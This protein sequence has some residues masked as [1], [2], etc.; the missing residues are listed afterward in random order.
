MDIIIEAW[1]LLGE[2]APYLLL[3]FLVAG[4]LSVMI[5]AG[6]VERHL[7]RRGWRQIVKASLLGV[8]LPLCSC[9]V[10]PVSASLRRHGASKGATVSFLASTPQ[11]GVDS[12][13]ATYALLGP[14]FTLFRVIT[15]FVS[16]V[17]SGLFSE[18]FDHSE[19]QN[20]NAESCDN[21]DACHP[22]A[23]GRIYRILHYG[24]VALPRDIGKA[25]L[26]GVLISGLLG[27]LLP[28]DFFAAHVGPGLP[29]M[30]LMLVIGIPLYVCSTGSIPLAFAMMRLGIS[31]GAALVFLVSGPATNAAALATMWR[32]LGKRTVLI[33]LVVIAV[34]SLAAGLLLNN[35]LPSHYDIGTHH[36]HVSPAVSWINHIS[37][38]ILLAVLLNAVF[39]RYTTGQQEQKSTQ[40]R[41]QLVIRG[42]RCSH[43]AETVRRALGSLPGIQ[44]VQ[45]DLRSGEA[46]WTGPADTTEAAAREIKA[47]GY[48]ISTGKS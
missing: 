14:I 24:F 7:G 10:I 38:G 40:S 46:Q 15:A 4:V 22:A 23:R 29:S 3:G 5:P 35:I 34:T 21:C 47:L 2:M 9:G 26:L 48:E 19:D 37:A 17:V 36:M 31:P 6:F 12:I 45:I 41:Q 33:Y 43:C 11:T 18:A 27:A 32:I 30:L 42:M 8:P 13:M 25:V 16:G 39:S 44:E 1:L 28:E 20:G